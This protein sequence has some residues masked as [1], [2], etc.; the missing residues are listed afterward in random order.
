MHSSIILLHI[1]CLC[2]RHNILLKLYV[3]RIYMCAEKT[4]LRERAR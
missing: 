4:S 3:M 1:N 2:L